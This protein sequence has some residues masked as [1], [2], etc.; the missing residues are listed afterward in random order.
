METDPVKINNFKTFL[1]EVPS[2]LIATLAMLA[3]K[4]NSSNNEKIKSTKKNQNTLMVQAYTHIV[5]LT[6][7]ALKA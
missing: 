7:N 3:L 2:E 6:K 5:N 1:S 4:A